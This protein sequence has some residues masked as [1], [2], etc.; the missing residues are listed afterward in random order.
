MDSLYDALKAAGA[1]EEQAR[2]A[3]RDVAGY[4]NRLNRIERDVNLLKWMVGVV[5]A[6]QLGTFW[7][8]WQ[9]VDRLAG[10]EAR[11][12]AIESASQASNATLRTSSDT[13]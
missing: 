5:I 2:A 13:Q 4:D 7:M 3:A 9:V 12:T 10:I 1:P 6:V 11:L 8:Q